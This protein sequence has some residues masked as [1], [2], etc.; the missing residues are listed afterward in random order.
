VSEWRDKTTNGRHYT[1]ST[2]TRPST[3]TRTQNGLNV[4]DFDGVNHQ[5]SGNAESLSLFRNVS[6][7]HLFVVS[8]ADTTAANPF[9]FS[10]STASASHLNRAQVFVDG[11]GNLGIGGRRLDADG[12]QYITVSSVPTV[13]TVLSAHFDW[14]NSDL[15]LRRE[16]VVVSSL[17]TF[18]TGGSTSDTNGLGSALGGA[19]AGFRLDGYIAEIIVFNTALSTAQRASVEAYLAAKWGISGVHRP[20]SQELTAVSSP[21][22]LSG[23]ALWLDGAD[24]SAESMTLTGLSVDTW[25]DKSGSGRN[26]SSSGTSRPT[27]TS[28]YYGGL[29]AVTFDGNDYLQNAAIGMPF[30]GAT[31]FV[32]F[33]EA[34]RVGSTGLVSAHP[35]TGDDWNSSS[36]YL[37]SLHESANQPARLY[38]GVTNTINAPSPASSEAAALGKHLVTAT[39]SADSSPNANL[40]Y[41]GADGTADTLYGGLPSTTSG[42]LIGSRFLAGAVN[43]AYGFNGKV[44]E[45]VAYQ[46]ALSAVDRARVE[47]YLQQKWAT[48][49]VPDPTPPVGAWLDKSGNARHATQSVSAS[50]PTISATAQNGKKQ[51]ALASTQG[52]CLSTSSLTLSAPYS[53]IA[54]VSSP[55]RRIGTFAGSGTNSNT[56]FGDGSATY[57]GAYYG[58][59]RIASVVYGSAPIAIGRAQVFSAV[60]S[61]G[62]LPSALSIWADGI[63]GVAGTVF[64]GSPPPDN[65][66]GGPLQIGA[67]GTSSWGGTVCEMIAY[68][69]ELSVSD[70][71]RIERYL[72]AKW[73]ITLAPQVSNADAQSWINRVYINGGSVSS[74]T[75][76]AVNTFCDAIDYGV[77][78]VSI[79]DRF[80]RLN[81]FCGTG[82]NACLVPL[83]R[84]QSLGGTQYGNTTDTN[85]GPFVVGDYAE[86]GASGG[87]NANGTSKYLATG[88]NPYDAG[89]AETD[90]HVSGYF[91][92]SQNTSGIFIGCINSSA[93]RGVI[94]HPA[95]QTAGMYVRLGGITNS[96]IEN[97]TLS[98][99]N[100]HLLG[101]RRPG[102]VGFKDGANINA[103]SVTTG[104]FAWGASADSPSLYVFARN[105]VTASPSLAYYAGRSQAYS[106]GKG[107]TD[108]QAAAYYTAMQAFQTAL[109]RNV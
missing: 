35:A 104:S 24:S 22:E 23:C 94:F 34:V 42:T 30:N 55:S 95:Y 63:G 8:K 60:A 102:G 32:V 73:G 66:V 101:V 25:K 100:G 65:A 86:T 39:I 91:R 17:T 61:S 48:P 97:G 89:L 68:S 85:V 84:G 51:L 58:A 19:G 11:S 27:L 56:Q 80:Y 12:F 106:I 6:S 103:T 78:G 88:L 64:A 93:Q 36:G 10:S 13:P 77:G 3:G 81:L 99:R 4:I 40:R 16:G 49:T 41:D 79:R 7:G 69:K 44:C 14:A 47:K 76:A 107:M 20:V 54:V 71:Q 1:A 96:G 108:A 105:D 2:T 87:L 9:I 21:L 45:I 37:I 82:L 62:T 5:M 72:A 70:R 92:E 26:V 29:S 98:S 57:S 15:F 18:Q 31:V 83:Y 53:L 52:N 28:N 74:S 38:A 43:N 75:A 67:T 59:S 109:G 46:N 33:D 90:F 50:R